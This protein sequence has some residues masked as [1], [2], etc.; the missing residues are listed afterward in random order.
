MRP[1]A[2]LTSQ[3]P[4]FE[5]N[6]FNNKFSLCRALSNL[7][8]KKCTII[9]CN[10]LDLH[11]LENKRQCNSVSCRSSNCFCNRISLNLTIIAVIRAIN[12]N[13]SRK[14]KTVKI[15]IFTTTQMKWKRKRFSQPL[16]VFF[17]LTSGNPRSLAQRR[18]QIPPTQ[19]QNCLTN[20]YQYIFYL[21]AII[22][23]N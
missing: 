11:A 13:M 18:L 14:K 9:L 12:E 21:F 20:N 2:F 19:N 16:N 5:K 3:C 17:F 10:S 22:I 1:C 7:S 8:K 15:L 6:W 23:H 4:T